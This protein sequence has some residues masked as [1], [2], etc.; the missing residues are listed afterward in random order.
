M[1]EEHK[2][3]LLRDLCARLPYKVRVE[4][5]D[6]PGIPVVLEWDHLNFAINW[7]WVIKPYLRPL[8]SITDEEKEELE[9]LCDGL[10]IDDEG[11]SFY[12][13][14]IV[15]NHL[16]LVV[17]TKFLD[18]LNKHHFDYRGLIGLGLAIEVTKENNP[19]ESKR[20]I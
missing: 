11:N 13:I 20:N 19:Y 17:N 1:K 14:S 3:L 7:E 10:D 9:L 12:Y 2:Q 15:R 5:E 6:E 18:W 4:I 8:S 16:P